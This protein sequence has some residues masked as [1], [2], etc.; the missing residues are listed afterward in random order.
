MHRS[1]LHK[2]SLMDSFT[3]GWFYE[4]EAYK[5]RVHMQNT[6]GDNLMNFCLVEVRTMALHYDS[7]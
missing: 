5:E 7:L 3:E 6:I 2:K 4:A 1:D